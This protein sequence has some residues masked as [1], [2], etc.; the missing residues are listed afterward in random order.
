M[1]SI[2][3]EMKNTLDGINSRLDEGKDQMSDLKGKIIESTQ[4]EQQRE[5]NKKEFK[6]EKV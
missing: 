3:S 5:K 6:N 1:K 2:M 4:A